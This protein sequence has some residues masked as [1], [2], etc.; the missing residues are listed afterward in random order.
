MLITA[1]PA[2]ALTLTI[3]GDHVAAG[4]DA[5][6]PD[7]ANAP[8]S[9]AYQFGIGAGSAALGVITIGNCRYPPNPEGAYGGYL[10]TLDAWIKMEFQDIGKHIWIKTSG[11]GAD[12]AAGC[13][14]SDPV[15]ID[16]TLTWGAQVSWLSG[17]PSPPQPKG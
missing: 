10:P 6:P 13:F 11:D 2:Q 9:G 7:G 8:D 17:V 4:Y 15:W 1:D 5:A 14:N 12:T 3:I 16:Q